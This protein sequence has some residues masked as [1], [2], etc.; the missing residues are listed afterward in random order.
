MNWNQ[1]MEPPDYRDCGPKVPEKIL[2]EGPAGCRLMCCSCTSGGGCFQG[3]EQGFRIQQPVQSDTKIRN[4]IG[5]NPAIRAWTPCRVA[6]SPVVYAL[7]SR[8]YCKLGCHLAYMLI[9]QGSKHF[10]DR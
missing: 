3:A 6:D 4:R 1:C 2:P 5:T 8:T 7:S 10:D 9:A